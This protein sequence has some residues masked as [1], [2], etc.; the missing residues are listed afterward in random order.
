MEPS[1]WPSSARSGPAFGAIRD[2]KRIRSSGFVAHLHAHT[3]PSRVARARLPSCTS[4]SGSDAAD[5][6]QQTR[7]SAVLHAPS[8][9][10]PAASPNSLGLPAASSNSPRGGE[11]S[12]HK[13][14]R[15]PG[16][17]ILSQRPHE[18][19]PSHQGGSKIVGGCSRWGGKVCMCVC[20]C[21]ACAAAPLRAA[22]ATPPARRRPPTPPPD[23]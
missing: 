1:A 4:G 9:G 5:R 22:G 20:V 13:A 19:L 11:P 21:G 16:C 8:K 12:W 15:R 10:L 17:R 7:D 2:L 6:P 14:A 3:D 18:R 23:Q